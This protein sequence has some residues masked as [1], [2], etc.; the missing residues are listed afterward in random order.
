MRVVDEVYTQYPFFG[1][2]QMSSY[3]RSKG[4]NVGR[5]KIR[6][7]YERLGLQ[8]VCPG[9]HTSKPHPE[10]KIYPYLLPDVAIVQ[11]NQVLEHGHH[12]YT[13]AQRVCVF[14]GYYRLVQPICVGLGI[15]Y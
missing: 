14:N 15:K 12:I 4:H 3:L 10:H 9:P 7:I 13:H 8:A 2:R 6:S 11:R 1:S 5:S